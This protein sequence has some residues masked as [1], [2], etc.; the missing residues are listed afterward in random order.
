[1]L[2][3]LA[4][5]A[6]PHAPVCSEVSTDARCLSSKRSGASPDGR[7]AIV[8]QHPGAFDVLEANHIDVSV[9]FGSMDKDAADMGYTTWLDGVD[10]GAVQHRYTGSH[11]TAVE[12]CMTRVR[13][14]LTICMLGSAAPVRKPT[15][16]APSDPHTRSKSSRTHCHHPSVEPV[17][18]GIYMEHHACRHMSLPDQVPG[19]HNIT[20]V[21]TDRWQG[22]Y[23][24]LASVL[25]VSPAMQNEHIPCKRATR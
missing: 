22:D 15:R 24:A 16:P 10:V 5:A 4:F 9:H 25:V 12:C 18:H 20:L 7:S 8:I 2:A 13:R 11:Y 19:V 17:S 23:G 3:L 6:A 1:M 21:L 14:A